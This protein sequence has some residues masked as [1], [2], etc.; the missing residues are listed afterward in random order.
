MGKSLFLKADDAGENPSVARL[1]ASLR[2]VANSILYKSSVQTI[3][4][5]NEITSRAYV[6]S[7][8]VTCV[9]LEAL[10]RGLY[11]ID[12]T[13]ACRKSGQNICSTEKDIFIFSNPTV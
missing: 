13:L 9:F 2:I 8:C 11:F 10:P 12:L 7:A 6:V 4:L 1:L 3:Q 5:R